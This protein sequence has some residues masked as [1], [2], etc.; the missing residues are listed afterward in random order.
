MPDARSSA[1]CKLAV[2]RALP[3]SVHAVGALHG[4]PG[5]F[6]LDVVA[7]P[8]GDEHGVV[9]Q[10]SG[11]GAEGRGQRSVRRFGQ[12]GILRCLGGGG[13]LAEADAAN[14][15]QAALGQLRTLGFVEV[16]VQVV[17]PGGLGLGRQATVA[18]GG[19]PGQR[20]GIGRRA[21]AGTGVLAQQGLQRCEL[22]CTGVSLPS[23][24]RAFKSG[25]TSLELCLQLAVP[26]QNDAGKLALF[27]LD[28]RGR[29]LGAQAG[30]ADLDRIQMCS[31]L[32]SSIPVQIAGCCVLHQG[33]CQLLGFVKTAPKIGG[34]SRSTGSV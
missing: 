27:Q 19:A 21:L 23:I 5:R 32:G 6:E 22:G 7:H 24:A 11:L 34:T 28:M 30:G 15:R 10:L 16:V 26:A 1:I 14:G 13:Q 17:L 4:A 33:R 2:S 12:V 29:K 25:G 3:L 9:G 20:S 31:Q 18:L 8:V